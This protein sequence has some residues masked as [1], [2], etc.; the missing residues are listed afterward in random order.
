M[1]ERINNIFCSLMVV[2]GLI[3]ADIFWVIALMKEDGFILFFLYVSLFLFNF[4]CMG[5]IWAL[6]VQEYVEKRK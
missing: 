5:L 6:I 1:N 4:G 3:G 2:L